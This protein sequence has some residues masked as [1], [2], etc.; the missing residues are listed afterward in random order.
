M[1][2]NQYSLILIGLLSACGGNDGSSSNENNKD[3]QNTFTVQVIYEDGCGNE[4][5][6]TD[7]AILIHNN[8]FSNKATIYADTS[9]KISYKTHENNLAL[10]I[11]ARGQSDV[12]GIKPITVTTFIDHPAIDKGKFRHYTN[13]TN[14]CECNTA[15]FDVH[16]PARNGARTNSQLSGYSSIGSITEQFSHTSISNYEFCKPIDGNW[17]LMSFSSTFERPSESY[18]LLTNDLF[19]PS[20]DATTVGTEVN[21]LTTAPYMQVSSIINGERHFSN[22]SYFEGIP[23]FA[24]DTEQTDFYQIDVYDFVD[25]YEIPDVDSAFLLTINSIKTENINQ[26][27][28]L[29]LP[30]I[31]YIRLFD[32]FLSESGQYDLS[33]IQGLDYVSTRIKGFRNTK[34]VFSWSLIA[35]V[36]GKVLEIDNIDISE[37]ISD[38]ELEDNITSLTIDLSAKNYEGING[39]QDYQNKVVNRERKDLIKPEWNNA[40]YMSFSMSTSNID[41]K[42]LAGTMP[43]KA[44]LNKSIFKRKQMNKNNENLVSWH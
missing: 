32:I 8:D 13:E 11:I 12:D 26:S 10:S 43:A 40:Q 41:F 27:L 17:P 15:T 1:F 24:F 7:A 37:F 9:G 16:V 19:L 14:Q 22:Y 31:D 30:Q 21:I 3:S 20:Y 18:G 2:R 38:S 4:T 42:S 36:R 44:Q 34:P 5:I 35:P 6:A 28:N 33:D 23:L 25:I 39:Y 29:T